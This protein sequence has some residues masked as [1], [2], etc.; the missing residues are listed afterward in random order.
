MNEFRCENGFWGEMGKLMETIRFYFKYIYYKALKIF[1]CCRPIID[2]SKFEN[3]YGFMILE[4]MRREIKA[5]GKRRM[6]IQK[7]LG[8]MK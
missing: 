3:N 2:N 7:R 1:M 5:I 4:K 8:G 6:K